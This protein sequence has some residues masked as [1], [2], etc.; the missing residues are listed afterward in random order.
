[1]A[2][3][4]NAGNTLFRI[5]KALTES[6]CNTNVIKLYSMRLKNKPAKCVSQIPR[7]VINF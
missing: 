1:M 3:F 4:I 7:I 5:S 2:F 6:N